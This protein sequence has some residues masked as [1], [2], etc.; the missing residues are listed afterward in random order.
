MMSTQLTTNSVSIPKKSKK[1]SSKNSKSSIKLSADSVV[2][3]SNTS[4]KKKL[5]SK[6]TKRSVRS[7]NF[8]DESDS[9]SSESESDS[10]EPTGVQPKKKRSKR[11]IR[12]RRAVPVAGS[13]A[14]IGREYGN[15]VSK[16]NVLKSSERAQSLNKLSEHTSSKTASREYGDFYSWQT[17]ISHLESHRIEIINSKGIK[18]FIDEYTRKLRKCQEFES[19]HRVTPFASVRLELLNKGSNGNSP[20]TD[21]IDESVKNVEVDEDVDGAYTGNNVDEISV[22]S[23][24]TKTDTKNLSAST[25][26]TIELIRKYK[27]G[28]SI[29]DYLHVN[30]K[31]ESSSDNIKNDSGQRTTRPGSKDNK[32]RSS[33]IKKEKILKKQSDKSDTTK[34]VANA[35]KA[36]S[37]NKTTTV[38]TVTKKTDEDQEENSSEKSVTLSYGNIGQNS[39][40]FLKLSEQKENLSEKSASSNSQNSYFV[41][42]KVV[43]S[44]ENSITVLEGRKRY[45]TS[46]RG[47]E[48]KLESNFSGRKLP[49]TTH[50]GSVSQE[51]N[52]NSIETLYR[53]E[54]VLQTPRINR[55]E[56]VATKRSQ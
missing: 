23:N 4:V 44:S 13:L 6:K 1:S 43:M 7:R 31:N 21:L 54:G 22:V 18:N 42:K 33:S 8:T 53:N 2:R 37:T 51:N 24:D 20:K 39:M 5:K 16:Q 47:V 17:G 9:H 10:S 14:T 46:N 27:S 41:M 49:V 32:N 48:R 52:F 26:K 3:E 34:N 29:K 55:I 28:Q 19:A 40:D 50:R 45:D 36:D 12:K 56:S 35:E 15:T 38:A 30:K 11:I 25:L